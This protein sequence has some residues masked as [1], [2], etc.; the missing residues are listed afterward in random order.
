[1][2]TTVEKYYGIALSFEDFREDGNYRRTEVYPVSVRQAGYKQPVIPATSREQALAQAAID[3]PMGKKHARSWV[4][5][6]LFE[7]ITT[8]ET[9][10]GEK[11]GQPTKKETVTVEEEFFFKQERPY[12]DWHKFVV[13]PRE[14]YH[15]AY[16]ESGEAALDDARAAEYDENRARRADGIPEVHEAEIA[17]LEFKGMTVGEHLLPVKTRPSLSSRF[18]TKLHELQTSR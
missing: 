11:N 6:W 3:C 13:L 15:K 7:R 12:A 4:A 9:I 5:Y 2:T 17:W 10:L 16:V 18:F 1:M 14:A 8:T